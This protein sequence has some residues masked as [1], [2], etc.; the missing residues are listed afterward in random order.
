[1][2][3]KAAEGQSDKKASDVEVKM[4]QRCGIQ[5]LHLEKMT[6]IINDIR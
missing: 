1:M 2:Q 3:Q 6:P 4:K 5:F